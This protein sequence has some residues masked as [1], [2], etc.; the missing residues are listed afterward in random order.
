MINTMIPEK[1]KTAGRV[2]FNGKATGTGDIKGILPFASQAVIIVAAVT[3][4]EAT[5]LVLT[6]KTADDVDG[7]GAVALSSNIVIYK[8]DVRQANAKTLTISE[9]S[10]EVTVCFVVPSI[11]VPDDKFLVLDFA[12]SNA[13]NILSSIAFEDTYYEGDEA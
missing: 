1:L 5:D 9:D 13:A 12:D 7:A 2:L 11:L 4:A 10:A 8:D 3:M 6:V